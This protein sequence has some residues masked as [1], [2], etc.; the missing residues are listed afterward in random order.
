VLTN[1]LCVF[2]CVFFH[3]LA[4][5][6][7]PTKWKFVDDDA[8]PKTK[9]K[10]YIRIGLSDVLGF[11]ANEGADGA[12]AKVRSKPLVDYAALSGFR[13][14]LSSM[15]MF[16]HFGSNESFG[17]VS[18]VRNFPWHVHLFYITGGFSLANALAPPPKKYMNYF[19]ARLSAMYPLYLVA[20]FISIIHLL[21]SCNPSTFDSDFHWTA[22]ADDKARD[23]FCE[24]SPYIDS[25]GG[26]FVMTILVYL[27]GLQATPLW[28]VSWFLGF[29]LW[30]SSTFY[31][32]L[33][34]YPFVYDKLWR[35]RGQVREKAW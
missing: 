13:F 12:E 18:R 24:P 6:K 15:V 25:W 35:F 1:P 32:C 19:L 30:F 17:D 3:Q 27:T 33:A 22:Q 20:I 29:Y 10:K 21:V 23:L 14:I 26:N 4:P 31:F 16:M 28:T 34:I 11:E 8:L 5:L 9:T 2:D 7:F